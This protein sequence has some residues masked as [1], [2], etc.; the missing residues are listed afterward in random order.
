MVRSTSISRTL[1]VALGFLFVLGMAFGPQANAAAKY[2]TKAVTVV[3]GFKAGGG[4]D[5]LAQVTQPFLEKVLNRGSSTST[6]PAPT[7]PSRGRKW[8]R[9]PNRTATP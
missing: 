4:S 6:N 3:H 8:P 7:A 5:Q 2:P 9:T 1:M